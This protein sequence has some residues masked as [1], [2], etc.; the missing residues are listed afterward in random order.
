MPARRDIDP[1][2]IPQLLPHIQLI[3]AIGDRFRYRLVGTALVDAFGADYTGRF[4]EDL[5]T[6]R[7]AETINAAFKTVQIAK[8]PTFLRLQYVTTTSLDLVANRLYLPLSNDGSE[9]NMILGILT[10]DFGGFGRIAG[11][12]RSAQLA[13]S[14]ADVA[15][16][17]VNDHA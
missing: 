17:E 5:F 3:E 6:D 15:I 2:D 8:R 12:W 7:R 13:S 9:V 10:F 16:L 4:P 11:A 1:T 14:E